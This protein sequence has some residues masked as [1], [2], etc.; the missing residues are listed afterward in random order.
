MGYSS[1]INVVMSACNAILYLR[2]AVDSIL[3][4][5]FGDFEFIIINNGSVD[6]TAFILEECQHLD[7]RIHVYYHKQDGWAPVT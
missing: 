5:T 6:S 1:K 4:Q 3:S 2:K 7:R